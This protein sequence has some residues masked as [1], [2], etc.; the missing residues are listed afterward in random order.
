MAG[1][2]TSQATLAPVFGDRVLPTTYLFTLA[3][4]RRPD[5]DRERSSSRPS[6]PTACRP[7]RCRSSSTTRSPASL[8]FDRLIMG[9]M[10][11]GLIVGVAALGVITAARRRRAA[12]ADRRP[13]RDRLP[14]ADGAGELPDRVVVHRAHV[15][16]RRHRPRPRRRATTS[17]ATPRRTPSWAEPGLHRALADPRPSSS[18]SSTPSPSRTTFLPAAPRRA[19]LPRRSTPLPVGAPLVIARYEESK[20]G[21]ACTGFHSGRAAIQ[22]G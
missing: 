4:G 10:G 13:A 7:T 8:T 14:A 2:W 22:Y 6:S 21:V 5:S 18:S 1:I 3:A 20:L 17:S 11:L 16:R 15:D 19:R 9:F 12:P